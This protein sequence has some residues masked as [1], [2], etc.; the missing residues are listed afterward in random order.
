MDTES[1]VIF[2]HKL[3][4]PID[5]K[6]FNIESYISYEHNQDCCENCYLDFEHIDL[7]RK[8][9]DE[10]IEITSIKVV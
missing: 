5:A 7:Y 6:D 3:S 10:L 2:E 4:I 9:I 8:Q 1:K